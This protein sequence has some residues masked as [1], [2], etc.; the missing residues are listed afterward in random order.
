MGWPKCGEGGAGLRSRA[1]FRQRQ[2]YPIGGYKLGA[3]ALQGQHAAYI[4]RH[5]ASFAQGMR[6]NDIFQQMRVI[7]KQLTQDEVHALAAFYGAPI[8]SSDARGPASR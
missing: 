8:A 7:A 2:R 6:E 4:E 1:L 3:P 5:L